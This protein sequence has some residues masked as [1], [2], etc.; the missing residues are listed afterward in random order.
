[1]A[2]EP[3]AD[4][5]GMYFVYQIGAKLINSF[6]LSDQSQCSVLFARQQ[7]FN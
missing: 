1:M 7:N 6:K 4:I 2:N 3:M 5:Y